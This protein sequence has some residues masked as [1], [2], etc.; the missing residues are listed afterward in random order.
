MNLTDDFWGKYTDKNITVANHTT[1]NKQDSAKSYIGKLNKFMSLTVIDEL[2]YNF[3]KSFLKTKGKIVTAQRYYNILNKISLHPKTIIE[4]YNELSKLCH[5]LFSHIHYLFNDGIKTIDELNVEQFIKDIEEYHQNTFKF[6]NDQKIA[7]K[8]LCYFLYDDNT[9]TFGLYGFAGTG[10]TTTMTKVIHY[11]IYKNYLDSMVLSA[12]TNTAVNVIK[13][14]FRADLGDLVSKKFNIDNMSDDFD[15]LIDKLEDKGFRVHF[16]T[17]HK[18]LNYKNDFDIEGERIFIKGDKSTLDNYDLVIVDESSM[19]PLQ[20]VTHLF[21]EA[22]KKN[23][24]EKRIPKI[25]FMGDPAQLPPVNERLSIIFA[26]HHKDF[27]FKQFQ[28]ILLSNKTATYDFDKNLMEL[29]QK[30]YDSLKDKILSMK[31]VVLKEVMRSN[32]SQVIGLCN[33]IRAWVLNDIKVPKFAQY[34]GEKVFLYKYDPKKRKMDSEWFK[35]CTEY[36]Q[37]KNDKEHIS[38]IM[39]AWT[40]KQCDDFN[41]TMRKI[42]FNKEHLNKFEIGDMLILVDF[43]NVRSDNEKDKKNKDDGIFYT[44]E[45][46]KVTDIDKVTK[47][48]SEFTENLV[49]KPK[50]MKNILDIEEKYIRT[51]KTINSQT[52]RKY[53]TWKLYVHKVKDLMADTIPKTYQ[54]YVIDDESKKI[55]EEDRKIVSEEIRKLRNYYKNIHKEH[56]ESIDTHVIRPLWKEL[57]KKMVDPFAN[58]NLACCVT[59]HKSQSATFY[60]VF[61]D[62]HNILLN[63]NI[64]EAKRCLYTAVTRTSNELHLLI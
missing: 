6:T 41:E 54:I 64:D 21:E 27:D 31:C 62:L 43:Y 15:D 7:I 45:Q 1:S 52:K 36:N 42:L 29:M 9:R 13:S 50:G 25:L 56:L 34:R 18:L 3:M 44:S 39:L 24:V 28:H 10:K 49:R 5:I 11:L 22:H 2:E 57:N 48:V 26:K 35:K 63:K 55:L 60:N 40:N 46:I 33:E 23:I 51:V 20:I 59:I 16:L 47:A 53:N 4:D 61:V 8:N 38:N 37:S 12:P 17:T 19:L 14:K 30:R 58:V 32:N